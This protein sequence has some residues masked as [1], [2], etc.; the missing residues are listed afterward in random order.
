MKR[1]GILLES[2]YCSRYLYQ[3]INEL[4]ESNSLDLFFLLNSYSIENLRSGTKTKPRM[5]PRDFFRSIELNLFELIVYIEYK[6]LSIFNQDIRGHKNLRNID[7]FRKNDIIYL[8]PIFSPSRLIVRYPREDIETVKSLKLDLIIRGNAPGIFKGDI[9]SVAKEGIISFHHGDNRWNRG[10]P[11]AFWEVYLKKPST[12]FIIQILTESL[13]GGIVLFRGDL[14][15]KRSFTENIVSLYN[16]SNPYLAKIIL[17]YAADNKLPSPEEKFPFA[18]HLLKAPTFVQ[19]IV[20][21]LRTTSSY[22]FATI[23]EKVFR[24]Q[25]RWEVAF[26]NTPWRHAILEKGIQIKNLPNRFFA[27]PFVITK[28]KRTICYVE[29][30]CFREGKGCITAIELFEDGNYI[31]LGPVIKE[32]F[33]MSFPFLFE[34]QTELYM[35]PET[36][37]SNSIRL[38]KCTEFPLTWKYQRNIFSGVNAADPMI[39]KCQG[40][41]WLLCNMDAGGNDQCSSLWAF[42]SESPL[43]DKWIA[44]EMNPLI[45]DSSIARNG[46]ILDA[47]SGFP[48]RC[49]QKQGFNAY[50]K[51]LTLARIK[52][53][54]PSSFSEEDIGRIFPGFFKKLNG[55]HH[56]HGN[57][58]FTVYDYLRAES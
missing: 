16:N 23:E 24:K 6:L 51:E 32:P 47:E 18:G 37:N 39:F 28:N 19:S 26:T 2:T 43:S 34:Y 52:E 5:Q 4:A 46:G 13:D 31:V 45:F 30:Y 29:D 25:E 12:G 40:K 57:M 20:Y 55:C 15:T 11:P 1:I 35:V 38:Y 41:W 50:G 44:H 58:N 7:N 8:N 54:S 10:G 21:L 33:H 17:Q 42:Y 48:I 56:I 27:D 9:L 53:L 3:T 14:P 36:T 22:I 49:R